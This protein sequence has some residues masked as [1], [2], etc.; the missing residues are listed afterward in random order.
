MTG[1]PARVFGL[2]TGR[3]EQGAP[4]DITI[5]DL[6]NER[7]VDPSTFASKSNNTPFGGW[8]LQGWT[9]ATIVDGK[10][11]YNESAN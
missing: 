7:A 4:A 6:D 9:V 1:D 3:L 10:V 2:P 8:K 5:V 11:V